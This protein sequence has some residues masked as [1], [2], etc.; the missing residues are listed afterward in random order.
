MEVW[1]CGSQGGDV[2]GRAR[3]VRAGKHWRASAW[4]RKKGFKIWRPFD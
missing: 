1:R 4:F 3:G 2:L